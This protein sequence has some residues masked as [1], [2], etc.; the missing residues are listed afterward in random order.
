MNTKW[1]KIQNFLKVSS[2]FALLSIKKPPK[3]AKIHNV[4]LCKK[5]K[6]DDKLAFTNYLWVLKARGKYIYCRWG[7]GWWWRERYT[8]KYCE[9]LITGTRI[10]EDF[11]F[12]V[13]LYFQNFS[14]FIIYIIR[15]WYGWKNRLIFH[16][17]NLENTL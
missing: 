9:Q 14:N 8:P 3:L 15:K 7:R 4:L 13:F 17:R 2:Y 11:L 1:Q 12:S 6:K 16:I 10:T 5:K